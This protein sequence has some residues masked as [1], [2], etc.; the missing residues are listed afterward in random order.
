MNA[1]NQKQDTVNG[2]SLTGGDHS[3]LTGG[4]RSILI[5][6]YWDGDRRR[7]A[8]GYIGKNGLKPNVPYRLDMDKQ[9]FVEVKR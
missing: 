9:Q 6:R 5:N 8:V 7:I 4:R 2:V 3:I 1:Q